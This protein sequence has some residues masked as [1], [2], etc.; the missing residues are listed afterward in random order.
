MAGGQGGQ[1]ARREL[2]LGAPAFAPQL[3]ADLVAER[4]GRKDGGVVAPRKH[5][6]AGQQLE[7]AMPGPCALEVR[8]N[9]HR[10]ALE[11]PQT[12]TD[13]PNSHPSTP[14]EKIVSACL[15]E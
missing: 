15:D 8:V 6:I 13:A 12:F 4:Q 2:R 10:V 1:A 14:G 5:A 7:R 3:V 11:R 9:D